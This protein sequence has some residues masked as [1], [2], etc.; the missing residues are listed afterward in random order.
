[1]QESAF[2]IVWALIW[3]GSLTFAMEKSE[4]ILPGKNVVDCQERVM[5]H[6]NNTWH[7]WEGRDSV[8]K[9]HKGEEG[10]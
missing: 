9:C 7:S 5:G 4:M 10:G 1:M 8:I 6:S 2:R 3:N